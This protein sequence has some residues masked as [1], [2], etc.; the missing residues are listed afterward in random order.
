MTVNRSANCRMRE[1][2]GSRATIGGYSIQLA[3]KNALNG[4][5]G[6]PSAKK[7]SASSSDRLTSGAFRSAPRCM[8]QL[9]TGLPAGRRSFCSLVNV[10]YGSP[11]VSS[12]RYIISR[13]WNCSAPNLK[14]PAFMMWRNH[15]TSSSDSP[16]SPFLSRYSPA[17]RETSLNVSK[18]AA[19]DIPFAL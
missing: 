4:A 14:M 18:T 12:S 3:Q 8:W 1:S 6:K 19:S 10:I 16:A 9:I 13:G 2:E 11:M 15:I 5:A 7:R 17:R